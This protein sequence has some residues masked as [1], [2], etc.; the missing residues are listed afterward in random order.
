[1]GAWGWGAVPV[2]GIKESGRR[3]DQLWSWKDSFT[4][5]SAMFP[6]I[7]YVSDTLRCVGCGRDDA[8]RDTALTDLTLLGPGE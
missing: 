2:L 8:G 4:H 3:N 7:L 6:G 1:M 5:R